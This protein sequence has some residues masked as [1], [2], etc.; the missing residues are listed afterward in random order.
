M[1]RQYGSNPTGLRPSRIPIARCIM[2]ICDQFDGLW[3]RWP[4][5]TLDH[6]TAARIPGQ[7]D[8]GMTAAHFAPPSR[9]RGA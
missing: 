9:K 7:G 1:V 8:E 5:P 6:E 3:S 2:R 4:C